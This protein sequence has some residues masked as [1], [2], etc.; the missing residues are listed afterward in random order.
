MILRSE[1]GEQ[2]IGGVLFGGEKKENKFNTQNFLL[3]F[4]VVS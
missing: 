2:K 4:V 1:C 3:Y